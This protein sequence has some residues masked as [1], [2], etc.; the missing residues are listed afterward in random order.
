MT[1]DFPLRR[2]RM[3]LAPVAAAALLAC[4][5]AAFAQA[6]AAATTLPPVEVIG[7]TP[8]P[9]IGLPKEQIPANVQTAKS[10][11]ID[12]SHALDLTDFMSRRLGSV[13]INEVQNNPFQPDVNFRGFTASPLLGTPQG[14]SVYVDGV[15]MNQP[16]GDVVSWDLIPRSAISNITLMPGSNPLFGLNTLGGALSVVTKNGW[17]NP[18][19]SVQLSGGS[20]G[21]IALEF[22]SG[23]S[24][25]SGLGW[26]VTGNRFHDSGWRQASP[27]DVSQLFGK[28]GFKTA[29]TTLSLSA[30]FANNDMTGNGLQEQRLL[31]SDYSSIYT[32]PDNTRNRS[33]MLNLEATHHLDSA[34]SFSGNAYY[35]RIHTPTIN[36]DVNDDSLDQSVYQPSAAERTAL[37]NAGYTGFPVAGANAANTPFPKWRCIAN[38]LLADEPAEKCTGILNTTNTQQSNYGLSGQL[39]WDGKLGG[40]GNV[41]TAGGALDFSRVDF[42][43][44]SELGYI[45]PDHSV[46]GV[47]SFEDGSELSDDGPPYDTRVNLSGRTRTW[48]LF[49]TDTLALNE[50][51]HLTLSGR[52][53]RTTVRNRDGLNPG[54]GPGSL[55]GDY[56]F[57]HFNPAIGLTW[58]PS[59]QLNAY[60]GIT[61]GSRAPSSIELGCAD[62]D[63]PCK[64]PNSFAGDP[65]LKQVVTRTIELGLRG[66]IPNQFTWNVGVF[67]ADNSD[68]ILFVADNAAGF[69]YFKN[70]GKT[71]RQGVEAGFNARVTSTWTVGVNYTYLNA[72]YRSTETVDGSSNSSN[73]QALAG[74]PGVDGTIT[75]HPGNKIPLIPSQILKV[76]TDVQLSPAW[77]VGGDISAIGGSYARGNEN[78]QDQ[79]DGVNYIGSGRNG[80][81]AVLN[82]NADFRPAPKWSLF[83][84]INNVLNRHY[85]TA[86]QLGSTVFD[87]RGNVLARPFPANANGDFPLV[88]STFYSPGAPRSYYAGVKYSFD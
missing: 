4:S 11:D 3:A 68:D 82:L 19:S 31:A 45:N 18:G 56:V 14:L 71:R 43:Q 87:A 37:T 76:F 86:A 66:G 9:G 54:G 22:E 1:K 47:G 40:F 17:N 52:F 5:P 65:P 44:G 72:T 25:P 64:L 10:A 83:A 46:T 49:A 30:A 6:P 12:R 39:N 85:S 59:K 28:L 58:S 79:P 50:Q 62:P 48:S 26:Y 70:F 16:F 23:G 78:N 29:D 27:T 32:S 53:N 67:R 57:S 81:Y 38:A 51:T 61:Q 36:G 60:A 33:V 2:R 20:H 88:N 21:R 77:S 84:Q 55:D 24:Q 15:R 8:V 41:I 63:N 75:I 42:T 74:L 35:R 34:L 69:G 7:T 13:H 80:G 73:D